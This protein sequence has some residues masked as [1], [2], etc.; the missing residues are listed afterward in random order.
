M[1][2]TTGLTANPA[3]DLQQLGDECSAEQWTIRPRQVARVTELATGGRRKSYAA[4]AAG[5]P[6]KKIIHEFQL[7]WGNLK[8][9]T[10]TLIEEILSLPEPHSLILW[11]YHWRSWAGDGARVEF[12]M[13]WGQATDALEPPHGLLDTRFNPVVKV[14]IGGDELEYLLKS[15]VDYEADEPDAGEVWFK[16][17]ARVFKLS[18]PPDAGAKVIARVVPIFNVIETPE[19]ESVFRDVVR[20]PRRLVLLEKAD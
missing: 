1:I 13:P 15:A 2:T 16:E 4:Q 19:T 7:D 3:L 6:L 18:S 14:G 8:D 5:L 12:T 17:D 9:P 11:R 10:R 20:E